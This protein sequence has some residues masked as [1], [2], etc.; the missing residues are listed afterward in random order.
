MRHLNRNQ[1]IDFPAEQR[2]SK[3]GFCLDDLADGT[4]LQIETQHRNYRLIKGADIHVR[5]SGHPTFCPEP[6]EVEFEGSLES[7]PKLV[8][9]PGFI[10]CGMYMVFKHPLFGSVTTSRI[11]EIHKLG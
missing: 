4:A 3:E 7:G 2:G 5:I 11:L 9:I 6:V 10:G 1:E 8:P